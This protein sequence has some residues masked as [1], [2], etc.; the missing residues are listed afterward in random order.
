MAKRPWTPQEDAALRRLL[1]AGW[2]HQRIGAALG[3][4]SKQAVTSRWHLLRRGLSKRPWT[5]EEDATLRDTAGYR[6]CAQIAATLGRTANAVHTRAS[7]LGIHWQRPHA[8]RNHTGFTANEVA[9]LLGIP[10]AKQVTGWIEKGYLA[11]SRRAPRMDSGPRLAYRVYPDA[12]RDFLRDYPWLY[13]RERIA[14]RGWAAY[15]AT[16]PREEWVGTGAAARLL[17]LTV[18][19]VALAIRKGDIRAEKV[20]PNWVI[21]MGAIRAYTPPPIG[22]AGKGRGRKVGDELAARRARNIAAR[23]SRTY[24]QRPETVAAAR[25]SRAARRGRAA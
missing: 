3:G 25:A 18:E 20:G 7:L 2:T 5:A 4:R 14:D 13:R 1:D 15:V 19:G 22:G 21:P 16:L 11:G 9:R 10:C 8:G 24:T 12:L 6:T 23:K 17:Y